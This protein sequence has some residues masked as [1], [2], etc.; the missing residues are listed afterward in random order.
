M[1][2]ERSTLAGTVVEVIPP[3]SSAVCGV[4][5]MVRVSPPPTPGANFSAVTAPLTKKTGF[6][7]PYALKAPGCLS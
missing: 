6:R 2:A 5:N 1:I 3:W 4:G 7:V